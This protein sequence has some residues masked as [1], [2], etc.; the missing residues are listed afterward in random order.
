MKPSPKAWWQEDDFAPCEMVD[1]R[2]IEVDDVP[3]MQPIGFI[4]FT[5]PR[6]RVKAESRSIPKEKPHG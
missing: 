3:L 1:H 2:T 6:Y 5:K 4:W